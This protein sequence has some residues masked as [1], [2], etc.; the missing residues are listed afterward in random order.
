MLDEHSLKSLLRKS[1]STANTSTTAFRIDRVDDLFASIPIALA[2]FDVEGIELNL[3]QGAVATLR[4]DLPV[5]TVELH[6]VSDRAYTARL[7]DF[8]D[9]TLQYDVYLID[10][11][12]GSRLD[13]RNLLATPRARRL[14]LKG[15]PTLDLAIATGSIAR[16][17]SATELLRAVPSKST[18]NASYLHAA[19]LERTTYDNYGEHRPV[20]P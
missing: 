13:C 20:W 7:F 19:L 10:E 5:V 6:V 1:S 12:C 2:H 8:I 14:A 9:G 3:L 17:A 18:R 16:M 4:R 11:V 15:S